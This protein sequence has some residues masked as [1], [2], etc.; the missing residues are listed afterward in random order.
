MVPR[1]RKAL[2]Q[3]L[4]PPGALEVVLVL[5]HESRA[6]LRQDRAEVRRR[7]PPVA[8]LREGVAEHGLAAVEHA[9][10]HE[11]VLLRV[12]PAHGVLDVLVEP[13]ERTVP[14]LDSPPDQG[15]HVQSTILNW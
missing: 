6:V 5:E 12:V 8:P 14:H 7:S 4:V 2:E 13:V 9:V 11:V 10:D 1:G 3:D 15:Q